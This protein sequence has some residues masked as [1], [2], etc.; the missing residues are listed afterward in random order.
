MIHD[1]EAEIF[2]GAQTEH[3]GD[4]TQHLQQLDLE[5]WAAPP[6]EWQRIDE[7]IATKR[8]QLAGW[9]DPIQLERMHRALHIRAP[10]RQ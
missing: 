5:R 3:V 9:L 6:H 8:R 2:K 7:A 1:V 10:R 4:L